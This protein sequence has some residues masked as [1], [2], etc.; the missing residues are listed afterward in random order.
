MIVIVVYLFLYLIIRI[1]GVSKPCRKKWLFGAGYAMSPGRIVGGG[2][3]GPGMIMTC[4]PSGSIFVTGFPPTYPNV[5]IPPRK[6][7]GSD[8]TY[9]PVAGS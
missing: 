7:I 9:R 1:D 8:S 6:P 4:N 2:V 3:L 5:L